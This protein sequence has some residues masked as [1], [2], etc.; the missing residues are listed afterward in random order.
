[1]RQSAAV[2]LGDARLHERLTL[3]HFRVQDLLC[4]LYVE[5]V[6]CIVS[7]LDIQ[8]VPGGP[9]YLLGLINRQ[10]TSIAAIDLSLSMGYGNAQPYSLDT[11][12]IFCWRAERRIALVVS[13]VL[14]VQ[15]YSP[16]ALQMRSQLEQGGQPYQAV[17]HTP[18]GL[19]LLLDIQRISDVTLGDD[20]HPPSWRRAESNNGAQTP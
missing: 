6:E 20:D 18:Q 2:D 15:Q 17:I 12:V 7:L 10:G 8:P 11:P 13:E 14:D 9:D 16:E 1:M 19:S 3:L 4:C 5:D